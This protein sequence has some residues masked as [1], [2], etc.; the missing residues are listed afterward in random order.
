MFGRRRFGPG[1]HCQKQGFLE[2][3]GTKSKV[4][5][6][7]IMEE[8][9]LYK[10][11]QVRT[12]WDEKVA[13]SGEYPC[14]SVCSAFVTESASHSSKLTEQQFGTGNTR[15]LTS[16]LLTEPSGTAPAATLTW[17]PGA[18]RDHLELLPMFGHL[19]PPSAAL[20][21]PLMC[22]LIQHLFSSAP[23]APPLPLWCQALPLAPGHCGPPRRWFPILTL[24]SDNEW[25]FLPPKNLVPFES[26][27]FCLLSFTAESE[28]EKRDWMEALQ[29][30][31][32]ETLSDYEV[33][34][35]IW[36]NRSNRTCADCKAVNP[37]WASINLCVVICKNCA[38]TR[39]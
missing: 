5:A 16:S 35:K 13:R 21:P 14:V 22:S 31:I 11:E 24:I 2:L 6:A 18:P 20:I 36:S 10:S 17:S 29:E 34:E 7:I 23:F 12:R 27:V 32:A 38:G 1:P 4:Y 39:L 30:A 8:I 3:K 25:M 37:D 15:A 33:A 26:F 9:W 19:L 28:R